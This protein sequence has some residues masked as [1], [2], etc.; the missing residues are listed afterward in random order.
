MSLLDR[1]Q[2]VSDEEAE[3][4]SYVV[5]VR[6]GV[7]SPFSDNLTGSCSHC[8]HAVYFRPSAPKTPPRMCME[9]FVDTQRGGTA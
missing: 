3:K 9:C 1:I 8:G 6:E 7:A 2:I 5:C 4:A